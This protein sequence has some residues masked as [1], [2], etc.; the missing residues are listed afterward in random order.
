MSDTDPAQ[1]LPASV[2]PHD[3]APQW[4]LD[5]GTVMPLPATPT[6]AQWLAQRREG[7][8]SS[9]AA[10]VLGISPW[11]SEFE[12][13]LDKLGE[14]PPQPDS[15]ALYWG[16]RLEPLVLAVYAEVR[17]VAVVR[18][19]AL[20]SLA[21]PCMQ[22]NADALAVDQRLVE[23]K[24][25]R[26]G[27]GWGEPHTDEIPPFYLAQCQHGMAVTGLPVADV[28]VLIGGN[29]FRIYTVRADP[30]IQEVLI[31]QEL[32]FWQHVQRREPPPIERLPD[33]K[34]RFGRHSAK[35]A[36]PAD[37]SMIDAIAFLRT[38]ALVMAEQEAALDEKRAAVMAFLG[39]R[40]DTLVDA[41]GKP[42][43]TWKLPAA[44]NRFDTE[45]FAAEHP[46]LY[47]RYLRKGTASRRL[48]IK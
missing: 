21:H 38:G 11:R 5:Q 34:L 7:I 18:P 31:E 25:A 20:R 47:Q 24:C 15:P 22:L 37:A 4:L 23:A 42:M 33:V 32:A 12:L 2:P 35:G 16:R 30:A 29:D 44:P 48:L 1:T 40:G 9:D 27:E 28:P 36:V 8:G 45:L 6:H 39:E 14:L 41:A 46:E 43:A 10:A 19:P 13:Y 3:K 26:T 17:G